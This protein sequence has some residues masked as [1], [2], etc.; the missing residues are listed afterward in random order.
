[1]NDMGPIVIDPPNFDQKAAWGECEQFVEKCGGIA[2]EDGEPN[3]KA[4]SG[5][6]PGCCSCPACQKYYWAWGRRQRCAACGF[7][8]ETDAWA[9]YSWGTHAGRV[10]A[11]KVKMEPRMIS[12]FAKSAQ[13]RMSHPYY[14]YGYEHPVDK[15]QDEFKRLNWREI[16]APKKGA[17]RG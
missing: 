15:P 4:A 13:E 8:Y 6:D 2:H 17:R 16:F 1:V 3:W 12:Y 5:A 14:R 11:G 7:E 10:A 9:M